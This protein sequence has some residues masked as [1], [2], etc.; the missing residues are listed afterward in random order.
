MLEA[1]SKDGREDCPSSRTI[2]ITIAVSLE[3]IFDDPVI[4]I[5]SQS[6]CNSCFKEFAE[7]ID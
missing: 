4:S 3:S 5:I 1:R 6:A 2:W 7:L